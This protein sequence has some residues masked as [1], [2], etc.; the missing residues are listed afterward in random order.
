MRIFLPILVFA[1]AGCATTA[2][3]LVPSDKSLT[4]TE[5]VDFPELKSVTTMGLGDTLA[6]K[7][8]KSFTPAIRVLN[9]VTVENRTFARPRH[10]V[11]K[12]SAGKLSSISTVAK[13]GVE[14]ECFNIRVDWEAHLNWYNQPGTTDAAPLC[15]DRSG[16]YKWQSE[17]V[18]T[19]QKGLGFDYVPFSGDV[20]EFTEVNLSSPTF[21]QEFIYNGRVDS[22]LKFVYREFSG[23]YL[24]PAF[25]QEVQYD[26]DQSDILGFKN[27]RIKVIAASNTEIRYVLESNF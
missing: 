21:V 2:P 24:K 17:F 6:S 1:L 4:E 13:T 8:Y 16:K 19:R 27:L 7:G 18:S 14:I 12:G 23:D 9:E 22:A 11:P 25:T 20:S 10:W 15:R 26:L 3:L 5:R